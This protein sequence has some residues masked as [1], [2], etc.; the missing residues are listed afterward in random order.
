MVMA[1]AIWRV[2]IQ[3]M[4]YAQQTRNFYHVA[5]C[6]KLATALRKLVLRLKKTAY[7]KFVYVSVP[8]RVSA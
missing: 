6:D 1:L 7:E 4:Q 3:A 8:L 2:H 5:G